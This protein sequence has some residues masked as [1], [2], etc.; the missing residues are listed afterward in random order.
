MTNTELIILAPIGNS[1]QIANKHYLQV[2][3]DHF[4][5][6]SR[7][8]V[9]NPVQYPPACAGTD[10]QVEH[11]GAAEPYAC[12]SIQNNATPRDSGGLHRMTPRR[13]ELRLPA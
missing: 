4:A 1:T 2:T 3:E 9:Q 13:L 5:E 8:A 10:T 11:E 7:K 6:A 12:R